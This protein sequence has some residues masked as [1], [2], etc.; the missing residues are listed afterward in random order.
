MT[1][2]LSKIAS[3]DYGKTFSVTFTGIK[4]LSGNLP[5]TYTLTTYLYT[6]ITPKPQARPLTIARTGYNTLTVTFDRAIQNGG[7]AMINNGAFAPGVVDSSDNKKVNYTITEV[8]AA[9]S[10]MQKVGIINWS[11]YNVIFSDTSANQMYYFNSVNFTTDKTSPVLLTY[12]FNAETNILTLTYNES[13][14]LTSTTG[15]FSST[16][17]T[18]SDEKI[19]GTNI[20]YTKMESTDSK[21]VKLLLGNMTSI[22]TYSFKLD[23]GFVLD[24]FRN[25]SMSSNVLISNSNGSALELPGPFAIIQ[26]QT[27]LSQIYLEFANRLDEASAMNVANYSIPG[28][29]ILSAEV[30]KNTN[31]NGATVLLTVADG[32]INVSVEWPITIRGLKGYNGSFTEITSFTQMVELKDNK[33]PTFLDPAVFDKTM[34]N[35]VKLNFSEPITGT[36]TV[37]VTQIGT[38]PIDIP[39]TVTVS[40]NTA[41][42]TLGSIPANGTYLRIDIIDNKITD[43]SGNQVSSM[44]TQL[45]VLVSY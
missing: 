8:E 31:N 33:K 12:E 22:G 6:D 24:N 23:V 2:N 3:T 11:G 14:V 4:D 42:I 13:V 7:Y 43:M 30:T 15:V 45:G 34:M 36:M 9:L 27:N 20:S 38:F 16:L 19:P 32:S 18:I 44:Q 37:K 17:I 28:V 41:I 25:F 39:N 35:A 10:G 29:A 40:G 1:I 21:V 5:A 26:S